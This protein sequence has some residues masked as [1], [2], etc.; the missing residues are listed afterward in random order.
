MWGYGWWRKGWG[1]W[2]GKGPWSHL[3]PWERPGWYFGRGWCWYYYQDD[4]E[5]LKRYRDF[6]RKE[7]E[8]VE[9]RLRELE[10]GSQNTNQ[11]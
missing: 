9:K 6:L 5:W 3:P 4:R 2:P 7:L 11:S 8:Y 10:I 1:P